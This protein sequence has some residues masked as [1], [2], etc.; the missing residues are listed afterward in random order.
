MCVC[1]SVN[2]CTGVQRGSVK[3][4]KGGVKERLIEERYRVRFLKS[5]ESQGMGGKKRKKNQ[6]LREAE[7]EKAARLL[8][9][10]APTPDNQKTWQKEAN[11]IIPHPYINW[12]SLI[13]PSAHTHTHTHTHTKQRHT[14]HFWCSRLLWMDGGMLSAECQVFSHKSLGDE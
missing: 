13:Q 3:R 6:A 9:V 8:V 11:G 12:Q 10:C 7:S 4:G 1:V 2:V 5:P 14:Q